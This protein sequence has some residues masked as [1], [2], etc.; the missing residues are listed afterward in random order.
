M[1]L[2]ERSE[3]QIKENYIFPLLASQS[4]TVV[5][6][7]YYGS[8]KDVVLL[9]NVLNHAGR[10]FKESEKDMIRKLPIEKS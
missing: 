9:L 10:A 1:R 5:L 3:T 8:Q 6:L 2:V 4:V 7:S